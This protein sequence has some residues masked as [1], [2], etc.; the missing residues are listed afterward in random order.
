VGDI[1]GGL[2]RT[3]GKQHQRLGSGEAESSP[4]PRPCLGA[5]GETGNLFAKSCLPS[6]SRARRR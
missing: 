4:C 5:S 1:I 3:N 6:R 2:E